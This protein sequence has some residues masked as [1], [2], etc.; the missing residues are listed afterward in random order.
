MLKQTALFS[1][2]ALLAACGGGSG[3]SDNN[4]SDPDNKSAAVLTFDTRYLDYA[5]IK[6]GDGEWQNVSSQIYRFTSTN[7]DGKMEVAVL[8]T[9][10]STEDSLTSYSPKVRVLNLSHNIAINGF[11]ECNATGT[12]PHIIVK[13]VDGG[14][15]V[16]D[17][18]I[19]NTTDTFI[20]ESD[21][22]AAYL[23][24]ESVTSDLI[25]HGYSGGTEYIYTAQNVNL[26][27]G[28][29]LEVDIKTPLTDSVS[30]PAGVRA[31]YRLPGSGSGID[32]SAWSN[33]L[34]YKI[35]VTNRIAGDF[36]RIDK[37][38]EGVGYY[39]ANV[40]DIDNITIPDFSAYAVYSDQ[41]TINGNT[42]TWQ[43]PQLA[44]AIPEGYSDAYLITAA[45]TEEQYIA[46]TVDAS[47]MVNNTYSL[48]LVDF[49]AL[50]DFPFTFANIPAAEFADGF[51]LD[52]SND[53]A[54]NQR[55]YQSVILFSR[56]RN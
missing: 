4:N 23:S 6:I 12:A 8:T 10:E 34:T 52:V 42:L 43:I 27:S 16:Y 13:S 44:D 30:L 39:Q 54:Y 1:A 19:T 20:D 51:D 46:Y 11:E 18:S 41:L 50:P 17:M 47:L 5:A 3:G 33:N 2:I 9:C 37:E 48:E 36:Y 45:G 35:P 32:T 14:V 26:T 28:Q 53:K 24:G 15:P 31:D 49:N 29:T 40:E 25:I 56:E 21:N 55:G 7:P 22:D 38:T